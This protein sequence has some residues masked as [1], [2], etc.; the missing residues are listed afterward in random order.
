[1]QFG[2]Q[3]FSWREFSETGTRLLQEKGTR[4]SIGAAFDNYLREDPGLLYSINGKIYLGTVGYDGQTP[5][6]H[7]GHDGRNL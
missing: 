4:Y 5:I 3:S 6:R 1:V 2:V 7:T